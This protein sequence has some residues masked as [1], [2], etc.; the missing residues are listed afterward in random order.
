MTVLKL[1]IDWPE[2]WRN[3]L[4]CGHTNSYICTRQIYQKHFDLE[5][6]A[7]TLDVLLLN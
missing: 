6:V 5:I 7:K 4:N 2:Y 1:F 3:V